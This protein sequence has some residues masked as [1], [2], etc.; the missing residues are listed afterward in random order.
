[1]TAKFRQVCSRHFYHSGRWCPMENMHMIH[2]SHSLCSTVRSVKDRAS[3]ELIQ[4]N[5]QKQLREESNDSLPT[6]LQ[7]HP[8][9]C[10]FTHSR[11][12]LRKEY[13]FDKYLQHMHLL[14]MLHLLVSAGQNWCS[15]LSSFLTDWN[16]VKRIQRD[17]IFTGSRTYFKNTFKKPLFQIWKIS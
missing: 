3:L 7:D 6:S 16:T 14:K 13:P 8:L 5:F 2:Q 1:M 12:L 17:N 11:H 10:Y 15:T 4:Q 9:R